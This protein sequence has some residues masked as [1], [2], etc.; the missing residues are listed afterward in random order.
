MCLSGGVLKLDRDQWTIIDQGIAFYKKI[1]PVIRDGYT[2]RF[3]TE[4][5]S[6]RHPKGWQGI[7]RIGDDGDAY[8]LFHVFD[9]ELS[10]E[11]AVE[12]PELYEYEIQDVYS[13][14]EANVVMKSGRLSYIPTEN[15]KAAAVYLRKVRKDL[16]TDRPA[17]EALM[18]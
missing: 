10:A 6:Y 18:A 17:D 5:S 8:A 1:A 7:L 3:G 16:R 13:D 14:S 11:C 9:G 2:Y 12:I 4:I 15:R